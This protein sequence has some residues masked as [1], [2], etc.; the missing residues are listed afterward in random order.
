VID[1]A[2]QR[3]LGILGDEKRIFRFEEGDVSREEFEHSRL[4]DQV[5]FGPRGLVESLG[6]TWSLVHDPRFAALEAKFIVRRRGRL[7]GDADLGK[8][9]IS[10]NGQFSSSIVDLEQYSEI[11][12]EGRNF[13]CFLQHPEPKCP[14]RQWLE[15]TWKQ[16]MFQP[17]PG[18]ICLCNAADKWDPRIWKDQSDE[19]IWALIKREWPNY[20]RMKGQNSTAE[21][22]LND[23]TKD[24]FNQRYKLVNKEGARLY[25]LSKADLAGL[26]AD[27]AET[28]QADD[29]TTIDADD[30]TAQN[31]DNTE[32]Y[33]VSLEVDFLEK[34]LTYRASLR[35]T[36]AKI[37]Q[38]IGFSKCLNEIE[39]AKGEVRLTDMES[40][41]LLQMVY[42]SDYPNDKVQLVSNLLQYVTQCFQTPF[43]ERLAAQLATATQN[44]QAVMKG[45]KTGT[46]KPVNQ[47]TDA[48]PEDERTIEKRYADYTEQM[49]EWG[50]NPSSYEEWLA[51]Y[52]LELIQAQLFKNPLK[53]DLFLIWQEAERNAYRDLGAGSREI[54]C[55]ISF[56]VA[57]ILAPV[58]ATPEVKIGEEEY[59]QIMNKI[60][61]TG[62]FDLARKAFGE[63][64]H[65]KDSP[66]RGA[67][68]TLN[69]NTLEP[70]S[71]NETLDE[72]WERSLSKIKP[73]GNA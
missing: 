37:L 30:A 45:L 47:I 32:V 12:G 48:V 28:A 65:S 6:P 13:Y 26:I 1:N 4:I 16:C 21:A 40:D 36:A 43:E 67:E 34:A 17:G 66:I 31:E 70:I 44:A 69:P 38:Q 14:E 68:T 35:A 63:E 8:Q 29:W 55:K 25:D 58:F 20:F 27:Y 51:G 72:I 24:D 19:V 7:G 73:K 56:E 9:Y 18:I 60:A 22:L 54:I 61:T 11:L 53:K 3:A 5:V 59:A 52:R 41:K 23:I 71:N 64:Y 50:E 42:Q 33:K 15:R 49:K 57:E 46:V 39:K 2:L 62:Y 10:S